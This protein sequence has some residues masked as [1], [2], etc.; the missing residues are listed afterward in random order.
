MR[1]G[2]SACVSLFADDDEAPSDDEVE[3]RCCAI[4]ATHDQPS[5]ASHCAVP[6]SPHSYLL[7]NRE[8]GKQ[9][10]RCSRDWGSGGGGGGR[11][12]GHV[13]RHERRVGERDTGSKVGP[14]TVPPFCRSRSSSSST[15]TTASSSGPLT[16]AQN[17]S[18]PVVQ[19]VRSGH[20]NVIMPLMMVG[21]TDERKQTPALC[22]VTRVGP[23][24]F[25]S[26][27]PG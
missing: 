8:R 7:R 27:L 21:K 9:G 12:E 24:A 20:A 15:T 25:L 1:P 19:S 13:E 4:V 17:N 2:L 23:Q 3:A 18:D 10:E 16:H 5:S 22:S 14:P 6:Q 11:R 26:H